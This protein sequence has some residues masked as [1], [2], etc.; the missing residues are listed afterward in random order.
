LAD[1]IGLPRVGD[2]QVLSTPDGVDS[3]PDSPSFSRSGKSPP[4]AGASSH[5]TAEIPPTNTVRAFTL[6]RPQWVKG[7]VAERHRILVSYEVAG[8]VWIIN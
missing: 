2:K 6:R 5:G 4:P 3:T 8:L 7:V 1:A